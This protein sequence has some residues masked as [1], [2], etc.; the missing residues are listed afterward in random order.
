MGTGALEK[1]VVEMWHRRVEMEGLVAAA[2]ALRNGAT[3][4]LS[5]VRWFGGRKPRSGAG[6][7][8]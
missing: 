2:E 6:F 1:A 7:V 8:V 3:A 5:P 4:L